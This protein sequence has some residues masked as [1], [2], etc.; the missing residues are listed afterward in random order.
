MNE[1]KH[2]KSFWL[3][4]KKNQVIFFFVLSLLTSDGSITINLNENNHLNNGN[5]LTLH[6]QRSLSKRSHKVK[7]C[8]PFSG[9]IMVLFWKNLYRLVQQ[10][11]RHYVNVLINK[12]YP[13]IKKRCRGLISNG[14]ILHHDNASVHTSYH[15]LSTIDNL[16][17]EL[18]RHPSYSLGLAASDYYLFPCLKKY[19][20]ARRYEDRSAL[21]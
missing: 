10:I 14:V 18:L 15:V 6:H 3:V 19:L 12:L 20:R 5:E 1:L 13:E 2:V 4:M 17:H 11:P 9:I 16:Q 21:G 8:I 7:F